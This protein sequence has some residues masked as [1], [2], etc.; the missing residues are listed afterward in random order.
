MNQFFKYVLA[1]IVGICALFA[2]MFFFIFL[3]ALGSSMANKPKIKTG[4]IIKE[5][6]NYDIPERAAETSPFGNIDPMT[7]QAKMKV[8]DLS[9]IT[10]SLEAAKDDPKIN[11]ILLDLSSTP[12]GW[13]TL[14]VLRRALEDFKSS[15]K[16]LIT[17]SELLTQ[18]AYYLASVADEIYLNPKGTLQF[19]GLST[20]TMYYKDALDK[21]EIEAQIAYAGKFKSATEPFRLNSMSDA[22][23]QQTTEYVNEFYDMF[24]TDIATSRGKTKE[25]LH[26]IADQL[27]VR[28]AEDALAYGMVDGLKH[29]GEVVDLMKEKMEIDSSKNIFGYSISK[30]NTI[31]S[32]KKKTGKDR[33]AVI[34]AEGNIM[35]GK[36]TDG[37]IGSDD[38][39]SIVRKI[40]KKSNIDGIVLRVNSGGGSAL[41][42]DIIWHELKRAKEEMD[43]PLVVSMGDVAASGGYYMAAPA[44]YI[45]AEPMTITGSIGV[46]GVF[47]NLGGFME[48]KLGL[49]FDGVKTGEYADFG[50]VN[51]AMRPGEMEVFQTGV[52]KIYDDFLDVVATGRSMNVDAVNEIAQGRVWSGRK[53]LEVGLIDELGGLEEAIAKCA[54][55]AE[56]ENPK[57]LKYPTKKDPFQEF[58]KQ[59]NGEARAEVALKEELGIL[60]PHYKQIQRVLDMQGIQMALPYEIEIH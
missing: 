18:K 51:R 20:E 56:V 3:F 39:A 7:F 6:F 21:L 16:F 12:N 60:Y 36:G 30:Y 29:Y 26:T 34:Y 25:E 54:E 49:T 23:R 38:Y 14:Q 2:L 42:S 58:M 8:A 4:S 40:R 48:N 44:D 59:M 28:D 10:A 27:K 50:S 37:S 35:T 52:D 45:L 53:A 33:I 19:N 31:A 9:D 57:I 13:A 22:N 17:Y 11:G 1:T 41:A 47:P 15:D 43:V 32:N 24:L 5:K 55:L 46:F